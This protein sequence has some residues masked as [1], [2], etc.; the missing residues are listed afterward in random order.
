MP[1]Q[2][3]SSRQ[4]ID[5]EHIEI[6]IVPVNQPNPYNP[7]SEFTSAARQ[8]R[9]RQIYQRILA[10]KLEKIDLQTTNKTTS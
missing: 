10:R 6:E 2:T 5:W 7:Y 9:L 3:K 4:K 8:G 1:T